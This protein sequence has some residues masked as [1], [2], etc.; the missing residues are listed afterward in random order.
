MT[1]FFRT[2]KISKMNPMEGIYRKIRTVSALFKKYPQY[3][4]ILLIFLIAYSWHQT[5][6]PDQVVKKP[7]SKKEKS[8]FVFRPDLTKRNPEK[9]YEGIFE[10]RIND[11]FRLGM[12][13]STRDKEQVEVLA[14][15]PLNEIFSIA[16]WTLEPGDKGQYHEIVFST[17]GRYQDLIVRL[18]KDSEESMMEW[19]DPEIFIKSFDITPLDV[20][21][22]FEGSHLSSTFYGISETSQRELFSTRDNHDQ[23]SNREEWIFQADGDFIRSLEFSGKA[24][25]G[26]RQE[27]AF[28]LFH[29]DND[30][31]AKE[32]VILQRSPFVL[33][34]LN[35]MRVSSGNFLLPFPFP[36]KHGDWYELDLVSPKSKDAE[37]FFSLGELEKA[38]ESKEFKEK[39]DL[40][41][42]IG[43][44]A[45]F[46]GADS[47]PDGAKLED[48]GRKLLYTFELK[49]EPVDYDNLYEVSPSIVFDK[50]KK[51]V[52]GDQKAGEYF[53]Y[54]FETG[55]PFEVF[56]L[57]ADQG[58]DDASE[59]TLEYSFDKE[60]WKSISPVE[61]ASSP[62]QFMLTLP[63]GRGVKTVYVKATYT[64]EDKTSGFFGFTKFSVH[65]SIPK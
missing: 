48:L 63:G 29:Y 59:I 41:V 7:E 60:N 6:T 53:M 25:G 51:I 65:A 11:V 12:H 49:R 3:V 50:E 38:S 35:G 56:T 31:K 13:A 8:A 23:D 1:N 15:S 40:L 52:L 61:G 37:N 20:R 22:S 19:Y 27:Y 45:R 28:E 36:L 47:F 10:S 54:R 64:G 17:P 14:R 32:P 58:G 33:D 2:D 62:V 57:N 44:R 46:K 16:T 9:I 18:K 30:V 55:Y 39:G 21:S 5:L 4:F 34:A 43:Q 24:V 26:G 42:R